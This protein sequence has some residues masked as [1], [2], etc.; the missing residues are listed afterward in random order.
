VEGSEDEDGKT[1]VA[2][3]GGGRKGGGRQESGGARTVDD[4]LYRCGYVFAAS[5]GTGRRLRHAAEMRIGYG[6]AA[7]LIDLMEKDWDC[8]ARPGR[9]RGRERAEGSEL[10]EGVFDEAPGWV[11]SLSAYAFRS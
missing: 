8:G 3:K 6:R 10:D 4:D 2:R 1:A 9:G 7:H 11:K 5:M